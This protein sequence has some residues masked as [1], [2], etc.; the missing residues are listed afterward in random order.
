MVM[1]ASL[2]LK[3]GVGFQS[4]LDLLLEVQGREL[5][6]PDRLLQLGRHSQALTQL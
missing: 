2:Q 4:L 6:K 5:E 3:L 1:K